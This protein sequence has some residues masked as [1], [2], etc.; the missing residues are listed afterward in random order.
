[1][2]KELEQELIRVVLLFVY[3]ALNRI[4]ENDTD[5]YITTYNYSDSLD[6]VLHN[7]RTNKM[8]HVFFNSTDK[9]IKAMEV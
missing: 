3:N 9:K 4:K 7:T 8:Y 1:M 5:Y 2:N 6:I